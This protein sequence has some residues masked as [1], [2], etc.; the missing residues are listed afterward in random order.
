M[1]EYHQVDC[2]MCNKSVNAKLMNTTFTKRHYE[3]PNVSSKGV[4]HHFALLK[5]RFK[6]LGVLGTLA[7]IVIAGDRVSKEYDKHNRRR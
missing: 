7:T 4:P 3:C 5:T 2:P 6:A 1:A